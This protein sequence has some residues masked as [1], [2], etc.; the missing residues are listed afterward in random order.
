MPGF[1]ASYNVQ[2]GNKLGLFLQP[3][4]PRKAVTV[5]TNITNEQKNCYENTK[6]N[7]F[8]NYK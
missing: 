1:V 7:E 3:W 4:G 5:N 8:K 2:R 6:R